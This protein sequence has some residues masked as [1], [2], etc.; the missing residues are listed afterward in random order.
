MRLFE[1]LKGSPSVRCFLAFGQI[2]IIVLPVLTHGLCEENQTVELGKQGII[3][4]SFP[5]TFH[6]VYWYD[7]LGANSAP[8]ITYTPKSSSKTGPGF[9]NN[10]YDVLKNGSLVIT[11]VTTWHQRGYKVTLETIQR[12]YEDF[13]VTV[14]VIAYPGERLP[15]IDCDNCH[16]NIYHLVEENEIVTCCFT[17]SRPP[18]KLEWIKR[19]SNGDSTVGQQITNVTEN[20]DGTFNSSLTFH[21]SRDE[22]NLI[23][24]L[25]CRA[26]WDAET[27]R[28]ETKMLLDFFRAETLSGLSIS[29]LYIEVHRRA[30]VTCAGSNQTPKIWKTIPS[31]GE[32]ETIGFS[33]DNST[34]VLT[35]T[36]NLEVTVGG[37]L[38]F[39]FPQ[40]YHEGIYL[41]LYSDGK[42]D[43]M[44]MTTVTVLVPPS[45]PYIQITGC[46]DRVRP[47]LFKEEDTNLVTC[48]VYGAHPN[49]SLE[50]VARNGKDISFSNY[51]KNVTERGKTFDVS[52]SANFKVSEDILCDKEISIECHFGGPLAKIMKAEAQALI[53]PRFCK[54]KEVAGNLT[55]MKPL[56]MSLII[57]IFVSQIILFIMFRNI[58]KKINDHRKS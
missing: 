54:T 53:V 24:L 42:P 26:T 46:E 25:V 23:T 58:Y 13:A 37:S 19:S 9:E 5:A 1:L 21:L 27:W 55:F 57:C 30:E 12:K 31:Q 45:P 33:T 34:Q 17:V 10:S 20:P 48:A 11:N 6:N 22:S 32:P 52:V 29:V 35:K 36:P 3:N 47:C 38:V 44:K 7:D 51:E 43:Q 39:S 50:W 4:C 8:V 15:A 14:E 49:V 56:M 28:R 41:C 40:I 16:Q 18:V 2:W